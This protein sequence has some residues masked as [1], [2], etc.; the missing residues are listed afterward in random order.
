VIYSDELHE[1]SD[2]IGLPLQLNFIHRRIIGAIG[3]GLTGGIGGAIG[4]FLGR[5]GRTTLPPGTRPAPGPPVQT[6]GRVPPGTPTCRIQYPG[7]SQIGT[8]PGSCMNFQG[9]IIPRAIAAPLPPSRSGCSPPLVRDVTGDCV[10]PGSPGDLAVG[11]A[12]ATPVGDAVM[13]RYG[14]ALRPGLR[15]TNTSTCL[16]GMVLGKDRLCYNSRDVTNKERLHPR[17]RRPL[18]T[19]GQMRAITVAAGAG[20]ALETKRKQLMKMGMIPKPSSRRALKAPAKC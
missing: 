4:G 6:F 8:P 18:L 17:G 7:V 9:L 14:P 19:G 10:F 12:T 2:P 3:G 16:P 13:G 15:V 1:I 5:G 11:G 20:R